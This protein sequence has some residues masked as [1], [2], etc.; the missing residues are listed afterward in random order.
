[1]TDTLILFFMTSFLRQFQMAVGVLDPQFFVMD[2]NVKRREE[3]T[4]IAK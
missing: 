4:K 1:M 2:G 3:L